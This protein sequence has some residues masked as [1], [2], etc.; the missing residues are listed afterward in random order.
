MQNY[1]IIDYIQ[2]IDLSLLNFIDYLEVIEDSY[3][4]NSDGQLHLNLNAKNKKILTGFIINNINNNMQ[5]GAN[6]IIINTCK[7][8]QNWRQNDRRKCSK[9]I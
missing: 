8:M 4:I 2:I 1:N 7:P 3:Q 5:I 9:K 6:N